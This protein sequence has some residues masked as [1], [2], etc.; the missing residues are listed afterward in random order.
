MSTL[1]LSDAQPDIAAEYVCEVVSDIA[2]F[3]PVDAS[4]QLTVHGETK[5]L[6]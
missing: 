1:N 5:Y 2:E 4:A 3:G 6:W